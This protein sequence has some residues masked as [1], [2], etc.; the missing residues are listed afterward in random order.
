MAAQKV[1][2]EAIELA[3]TYTTKKEE[4]TA[5]IYV[6]YIDRIIARGASF[7]L[8]EKQRLKKVLNGKVTDEKKKDL[9]LRL[10]ILESFLLPEEAPASDKTEKKS[11][12]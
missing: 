2:D 1:A 10:N 5:K 3:E 8:A 7:A 4:Q 9:K 11:E 6:T 12:L